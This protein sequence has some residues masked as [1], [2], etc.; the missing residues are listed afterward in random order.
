MPIKRVVCSICKAEVNKAQTYHVGG[1][2]RACRSHEGVQAKKEV[3]DLEKAK[4]ARAWLEKK[5]HHLDSWGEPAWSGDLGPKCWVCMNPGLRQ[6]EFFMKVLVEMEKTK[7][8]HGP[9]SPFDPKYQVRLAE[10]CIFVLEKDKCAEVMRYI[11]EDFRT[12]VDMSGVVAVCGPCCVQS[13]IDPLAHIGLG[14]LANYTAV[15]QAVM[16]P[17]VREAAGLE[18]ARDN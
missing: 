13:K 7:M 8:I 11:R 9:V 5:K 3:L 17:L 1:A 10:R 16:E 12:L 2:D 18:M 6:D 14:E 15:Y 4:K